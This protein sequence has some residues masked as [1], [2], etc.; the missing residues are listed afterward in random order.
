MS[1]GDEEM[2]NALMN[3]MADALRSAGLGSMV[4]SDEVDSEPE[5]SMEHEEE[6]QQKEDAE[7]N[8]PMI[9]INESKDPDGCWIKKGNKSHYG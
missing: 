6:K 9:E 5:T 7:T 3:D 2:S 4:G 1:A 8:P